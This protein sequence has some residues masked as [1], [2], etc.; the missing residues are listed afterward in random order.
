MDGFVWARDAR[1]KAKSRFEFV[2][3]GNWHERS[4]VMCALYSF[5]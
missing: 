3:T 1:A 4:C 2:T 5:I